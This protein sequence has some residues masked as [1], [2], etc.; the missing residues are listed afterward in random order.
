MA[1]RIFF[2]ASK[3]AEYEHPGESLAEYLSEEDM[4]VKEFAARTN[5][6]E[7][8]IH[9]VLS[10]KSS[11]TNDMAIAFE[12]VTHMPA[13]Y[14]MNKQN[15]YDAYLARQRDKERQIQLI[16]WAKEF[17]YKEMAA[18]GWVEATTDAVT[19][20]ANLLK[21]F[22]VDSA[23]AWKALYCENKLKVS[24]RISLKQSNNPQALSAWLRYGEILAANE[25][26][27]SDYSPA[28]LKSMLPTIME[29]IYK[30]PA[31]F[32]E[33]IKKVC[34]HCG[35]KVLY[36]KHLPKAP[37]SGCARW[38]HD[39]P[40]IMLTD[41]LKR[42]D[43]VCFSL[44]H[45]IGHILKHGKKD[46]FME[47]IGEEMTVKEKEAENFARQM[48][49]PQKDFEGIVSAGKFGY[50]DILRASVSHH[51]NTSILVGALIHDNIITYRTHGKLL[52]QQI[53]V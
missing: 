4:S 49:L 27:S 31:D 35:I 38:I 25:T 8:T 43:V 23:E 1:N 19:K 47:G 18:L 17:P 10:G 20:V 16:S 11:I 51:I 37:A 32:A 34:S 13:H 29:I 41:R 28:L 22:R 39:T 21:F 48:L 24:F 6:P 46:V 7:K 50:G 52:K 26:V 15:N 42:Y 45:E 5:K 12:K 3:L 2:D 44:M 9:A 36:I 14:W 33:Q 30:Q 53:L 40:C